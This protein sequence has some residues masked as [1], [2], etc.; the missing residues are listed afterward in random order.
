M[1]KFTFID[2]EA[3][4]D[5]YLHEDYRA[6]APKEVAKREKLGLKEHRLPCKRIVAAAALGIEVTES[7]AV[8]ITGLPSWTEH[9]H[10]DEQA[11]VECLLAHLRGDPESH[12]VTYNGLAA[13]M[14][15]LNLAAMEHGLVLPMQLRS[16]T[17]VRP[18]QWR[19]HIDFA[20]ELKGN[21]R[22][23]AHLSE[24]GL[25]M[26]LPVGLFIG[27]AEIER[28]RDGQEWQ[29]LRQRVSMDCVLTA[30]IALTFWRANGR[31]RVDQPAML[32]AMSAWCLRRQ[33]ANGQQAAA[34]VELREAMV[35]RIAAEVAQAA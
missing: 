23:W 15:L 21:G 16:D 32:H 7:G 8:S 13:E 31:V 5:E 30:M 22:D 19:R 35:E 24:I 11:V 6:V 20:L 12:I 27:K 4:W 28:P 34:L 2:V 3:L 17:R 9:D 25:R 18:G 1:P 26:G 33:I 14:P 29:A 10:G